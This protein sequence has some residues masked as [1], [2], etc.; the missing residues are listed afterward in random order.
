MV[1]RR[2]YLLVIIVAWEKKCQNCNDM[3]YKNIGHKI[4]LSACDHGG[5]VEELSELQSYILSE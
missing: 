1:E 4:W 5:I 3:Y 2:D